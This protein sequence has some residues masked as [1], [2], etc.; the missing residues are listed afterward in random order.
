MAAS[1]DITLKPV[2]G[3]RRQKK[4]AS[5]SDRPVTG[6]VADRKG[7]FVSNL[8]RLNQ[9]KPGKQKRVPLTELLVFTR[10]LGTMTEAGLPFV[11]A[12][13]ALAHQTR[14]AVMAE[15]I[16]D[17]LRQVEEGGSFASAIA[18]HPRIFA[19]LYVSMVRAGEG[20][21]LLS[22]VLARLATA[23]ENTARLRRKIKSAIMYPIVVVIVAL[24]VTSFLLIAVVPVFGDVFKNF[25]APLPAPTRFLIALGNLAKH[26]MPVV[27]LALGAAT[28]VWLY[29][30][31]TPFG[32]N[33]WDSYRLRL[34]V[35][36]DI[37]HKACLARFA[38]TF[39]SL[40]RS[41][42]PILEVLEVTSQTV[43]NVVLEKAIK[44]ATVDIEQGQTVSDSL[45]K[46]PVFSDMVIRM[47]AAG[48]QTGDLDTML[49]HVADFLEEE[50]EIVLAGLT[51]LIEP[52]LI[53]FLGVVVGGMVICM[54]L[55]IFKLP[56]IVGGGR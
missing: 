55:P 46:H 26:F 19:K 18:M 45:S 6:N 13:R 14:N 36:G 4:S 34:P 2:S 44:S 42:V 39:S 23:L 47:A 3:R 20:A 43:G 25:G 48:E 16:Q 40:V 10:Q 11:Q 32:R 51:T 54:F 56:E 21:G 8:E 53:V 35:F 5:V 52:I 41:G 27:L 38:R 17:V 49:A 28:Y 24:L 33:F 29:F 9:T 22:D 30:I 15:T 12:L 1:V 7:A 37:A 50:T 31:K